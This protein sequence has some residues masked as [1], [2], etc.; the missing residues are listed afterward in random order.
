MKRINK[1]SSREDV[2]A[3]VS[4]DGLD[5]RFAN[6]KYQDDKEVVEIAVEQDKDA[7]HWASE[8]LQNDQEFITLINSKN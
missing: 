1:E 3:A 6:K 8:E 7:I 5:L 4:V 2:I